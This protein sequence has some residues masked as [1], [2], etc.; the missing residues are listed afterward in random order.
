V[1]IT[2]IDHVQL[3]APPGCEEQAREFY[4]GLLGLPEIDKPPSLKGR[5][6][7]WFACGAQQLHVGVQQP[8][9]PAAKAHPALRV[10]SGCLDALAARLGE[11]GS[12]VDWDDA[13]HPLRRLYTND[14]WG[15]RIELLEAPPS[16][17][18]R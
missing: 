12:K 3:A 16:P 14:P 4:G 5:G 1:G 9:R 17:G 13:L 15:N 10:A 18:G 2:G 7:A 8:H 6:G 11:A